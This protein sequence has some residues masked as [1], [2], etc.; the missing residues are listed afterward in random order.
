MKS[1]KC[2]TKIDV[3]Q[4][5]ALQVE[6]VTIDSLNTELPQT[7]N[8]FFPKGKYLQFFLQ[9]QNKAKYACILRMC[10]AY[11]ARELTRLLSLVIS[12]DQLSACMEHGALNNPSTMAG[13]IHEFV[14]FK[15][16]FPTLSWIL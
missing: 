12:A 9:S 8:F 4:A 1:L 7:F 16:L 6:K 3:K 11:S 2:E 14:Y 13:Q 10:W 5:N 15:F